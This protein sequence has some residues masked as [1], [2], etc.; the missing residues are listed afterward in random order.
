MK[1]QE[2]IA[3]LRA[4]LAWALEQ[5]EDD[6]DPRSSGCTSRCLGIVGGLTYG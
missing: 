4:A 2:L 5:I 6:L 1:D 3:E